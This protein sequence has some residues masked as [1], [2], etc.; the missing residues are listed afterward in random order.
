MSNQ[1][2]IADNLFTWPSDKPKLLGSKDTETGRY[3]QG[4]I[5]VHYQTYELTEA[6]FAV[7]QDL[8]KSLRSFRN[9]Q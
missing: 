1:K 9:R 5:C 7:L 6:P 8:G 2:P 4:N 3:F